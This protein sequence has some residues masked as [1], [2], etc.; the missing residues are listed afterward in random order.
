VLLAG[1]VLLL[2]CAALGSVR[3]SGTQTSGGDPY[4]SVQMIGGLLV[5]VAGIVAVTALTIITLSRLDSAKEDSMI[6]ITS[7][8]FGIISAVIGA[9]L[10]IK[11]SADSNEKVVTGVTKVADAEQ[12]ADAAAQEAS[13]VKQQLTAMTEKLDEVAPAHADA[14]KAAGYQASEEAGR[15][16]DPSQGSP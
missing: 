16:T 5:V 8:A 2:F 14:V 9:Y 6:A 11:I 1:G 7:S 12:K 3:G 10:G 13:V 15:T 4:K